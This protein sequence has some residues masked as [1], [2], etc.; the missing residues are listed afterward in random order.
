MYLPNSEASGKA[1]WPSNQSEAEFSQSEAL[2]TELLPFI[3]D[4]RPLEFLGER[5]RR[6]NPSNLWHRRKYKTMTGIKLFFCVFYIS[7][8]WKFSTGSTI[9]D[10]IVI[11][12]AE[13]AI[14]ISS[15]IA[16]VNAELTL[17]NTGS[18]AC[19]SFL[20]AVSPK[21]AD[22]VAY[23]SATVSYSVLNLRIIVVILCC[24]YIIQA[25][26]TLRNCTEISVSMERKC[27]L[28]K[29]LISYLTQALSKNP[30][31]SLTCFEYGNVCTI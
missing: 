26:Y 27:L 3:K 11:S 20:V 14:D 1:T 18:E 24:C 28:I 16:K 10:K 29:R 15:Q 7:L 13:R 19:R 12:K 21:Q 2:A 23:F 30:F 4:C 9:N 8:A 17:E 31:A 6:K 22:H 5:G 25:L